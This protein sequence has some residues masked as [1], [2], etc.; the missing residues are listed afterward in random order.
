VV[1][2]TGLGSNTAPFGSFVPKL[3]ITTGLNPGFDFTAALTL[4]SNDAPIFPLANGV[5]LTIGSY[6]VTVPAAS[7]KVL[8]NGSKITGYVYQGTVNG[9]KLSEQIAPGKQP[10]SYTFKADATGILPASSN[11]V[12]VTLTIG[13][14]SST[15]A[16]RSTF[17]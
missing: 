15:A 16:V 2:L 17:K 4:N 12:S 3:S 13:S 8:K 9:I 6:S 1:Q 7:F 10:R 14:H 5:S 11:P